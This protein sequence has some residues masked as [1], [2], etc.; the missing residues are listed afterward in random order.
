MGLR[1]I[2][3]KCAFLYSK[4]FREVYTQLPGKD[5]K[6]KERDKMGLVVKA[7]CGARDAPQT[8]FEEVRWEMQ[9]V[10]ARQ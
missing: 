2:D 3:A 10:G 6:S 5:P 9:R 7:R 1:V 8:W 4:M